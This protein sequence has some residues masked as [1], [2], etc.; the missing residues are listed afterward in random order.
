M[1]TTKFDRTIK[2]LTIKIL[3]GGCFVCTALTAKAEMVVS[4]KDGF[5]VTQNTVVQQIQEDYINI[6]LRDLNATN[7]LIIS[8]VSNLNQGNLTGEIHIN[9]TKIQNLT[10]NRTN[11]NLSPHLRRGVN[12][13]EVRGQYH[14]QNS[15][16]K[17]ELSSASTSISQT[18]GGGGNINYN[19]T[20]D[21]R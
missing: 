10:G 7:S 4:R 18:T 3:V 21:V 13:I 5:L 11:I 14:P 19:L 6:R 9:G 12:R 16:I 2:L 8:K 1:I 20:I 15:S 17:I